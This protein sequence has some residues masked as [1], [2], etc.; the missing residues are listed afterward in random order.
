MVPMNLNPTGSAD[1]V[2]TG[3]W[4]K[5]ACEE[6]RKT[7]PVRVVASSEKTGFDRIPDLAIESQDPA[8]AF[9]HITSNETIQGIKWTVEPP[10]QEKVPLVCDMSSDIA[11]QPVDVNKYGLIYAGAQ[12]NLGPAGVTVVVVRNDLLERSSDNLPAILNY[13]LLASKDSMYN[14]PPTYGIYMVGL[15]L[16]WLAENGGLEKAGERS[17]MKSGLIYEVIDQ[18]GG[19]YKGHAQPQDRSTMNTTFTLG[20]ESLT[21]KFLEKSVKNG[22]IGLKGHR[23]VGGVRASLYN[24]L[25]IE[26]VETLVQFMK[27]FERANG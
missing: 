12:K 26:A 25:P 27:E 10:A 21:S 8:A 20:D 24:A 5:K 1:Y 7:G 3:H 15:V 19:F 18:S 17:R 14:T 22:L 13:K 6:A 23:S 16:N 9:L 4:S 11:S 2:L